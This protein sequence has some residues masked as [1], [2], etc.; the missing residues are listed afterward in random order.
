MMNPSALLD[1]LASDWSEVVTW[2]EY[3]PLI[4]LVNVLCSL[5]CTADNNWIKRQTQSIA[6]TAK[7]I[8][9]LTSLGST[10]V[11]IKRVPLVPSSQK[12]LWLW[13]LKQKSTCV[14]F[15]IC[16]KSKYGSHRV[17]CHP[18]YILS[19]EPISGEEDYFWP[20]SISRTF[21]INMFWKLRVPAS[22]TSGQH[23]TRNWSQKK[24][25]IY[26]FLHVQ[27]KFV[28]NWFHVWNSYDTEILSRASTLI[29]V[30]SWSRV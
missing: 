15:G 16:C 11:Q 13:S 10:Y 5:Q 25:N 21:N 8:D 9:W 28:F 20:R 23:G 18:T 7:R 4:W 6:N 12:L 29:K 14:T 19:G 26:Y 3:W 22:V 30:K 27:T 1:I 2:P 17:I 24:I